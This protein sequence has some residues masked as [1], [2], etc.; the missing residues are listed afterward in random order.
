MTLFDSHWNEDDKIPQERGLRAKMP[1]F[2]DSWEA[3]WKEI[4]NQNH[5]AYYEELYDAI[6]NV[7]C[8]SKRAFNSDLEKL[9]NCLRAKMHWVEDTSSHVFPVKYYCSNCGNDELYKTPFC[10]ICGAMEVKD[11]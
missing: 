11:D 5:L 8:S 10:P 6:N 9:L 3:G 4:S 1:I 2:E 7:M